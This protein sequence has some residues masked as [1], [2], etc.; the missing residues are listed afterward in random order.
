MRTTLTLDHQATRFILKKLPETTNPILATPFGEAQRITT[1]KILKP[2]SPSEYGSE[3]YRTCLSRAFNLAKQKIYFNNDMTQLVTFTYADNMQD[4]DKLY[5]DIKIFLKTQKRHTDKTIKYL[6]T[7][8]KQERGALHIHMICTP[9]ITTKK[10]KNNY[11]SAVYWTHGFTSVLDIRKADVNFKPYLYLFKYMNKAQKIGNK[12]IHS[13]RNLKNFEEYPPDIFD[14]KLYE[15]VYT[16]NVLIP[17]LEFRT[18]TEY[19]K[20]PR[21]RLV[22]KR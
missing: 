5:Y 10:N 4:L 8:E 1:N 13:S 18:K 12:F 6:F 7:I 16:E 20:N 17:K 9:F 3:S 21:N 14:K 2:S 15:L 19:Y 22:N 11:D